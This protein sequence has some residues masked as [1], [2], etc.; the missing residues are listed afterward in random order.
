[1]LWS[2]NLKLPKGLYFFWG[3]KK[4]KAQ[5]NVGSLKFL[6]KQFCGPK[7]FGGITY[8]F[9]GCLNPYGDYPR[10]GDCPYDTYHYEYVGVIRFIAATSHNTVRYW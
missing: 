2:Q 3:P 8:S 4:I 6:V 9:L 10:N 7:I 5:E 1:M